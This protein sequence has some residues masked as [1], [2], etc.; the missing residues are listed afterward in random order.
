MVRII[1]F[2]LLATQSFA[3]EKCDNLGA[4]EADPYRVSEPVSFADL[5]GTKLVEAC[6]LAI[7]KQDE[8]L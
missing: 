5:E 6:G 1:T 8:N 2:I 7:A 3:A 4:L